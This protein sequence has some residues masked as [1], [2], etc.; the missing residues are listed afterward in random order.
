MLVNAPIVIFALITT[1]GDASRI[2]CIFPTPSISHQ[3]VYQP[4][5]KTLSLR[6]HQVTVIT[7]NPLRDSNLT[8]LTE[9]DVS[10]VYGIQDKNDA[11]IA[12]KL[13]LQELAHQALEA[14]LP[15][16]DQMLEQKEVKDII[17]GPSN[18]YD[19]VM[20]EFIQP[21]FFAFA[22]KFNCPIVGISSCPDAP[23]YYVF[24]R[25]VP[26][27]PLAYHYAFGPPLNAETIW[28]RIEHLWSFLGYCMSYYRVILKHQEIARKHFGE[29]I[30]DLSDTMY[31]MSLVF[32]ARNVFINK[33]RPLPPNVVEIGRIHIQKEPELPKV[34]DIVT[35]Y[36]PE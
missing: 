25:G 36:D 3:F 24:S 26:S 23:H 35:K 27:N 6:G 20:I 28:Q 8:N 21:V 19:L 29:D 5:W 15:L 33:G 34:S 9:I 30:G 1:Y 31:N 12:K 16:Y 13:T 14:P 11:N 10:G 4:V 2:L 17:Q 32:I 22:Q 7:P 18:C